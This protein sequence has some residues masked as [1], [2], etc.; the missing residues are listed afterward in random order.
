L[1]NENI[2]RLAFVGIFAVA[3]IPLAATPVLPLIDFYDHLARYFILA[4][5]AVNPVLQRYYEAHWSLLPD[6]GVDLVATP[7]LYFLPPLIAAKAIII[8]IVAVLFSGVIYFNHALTQTRSV[9]VAILIVPLLYS[10]ILNWGFANFLLGLGLVFWAAG[11]WLKTRDRPL[12]AVPVSCVLAPI[13][14]FCHGV[15]FLLYGI[16]LF[17]LELGIF[18]AARD[19]KPAN[20]VYS[21]GLIAIQAIIPVTYF[22]IWKSGYSDGGAVTAVQLSP[23]PFFN[24]L[25]HAVFY[26]L[27]TIARVEEGPALWFDMFTLLIQASV[28]GLLLWKGSISFS[29]SVRPL[30]I[31]ALILTALPLPTLFG[32][33]YIADR[34]PLFSALAVLGVVSV[35]NQKWDRATYVC[36]AILASVVFARI[37]VIAFSWHAYTQTYDE[38][39]TI[40]DRIPPG[41]L[42]TTVML[43]AGHHETD[44]PRCEMYGPLLVT[45]FGGVTPLFADEKQQPLRMIGRLTSH[46]SPDQFDWDNDAQMAYAISYDQDYVLVC[47]LQLLTGSLPKSEDVVERTKHF[48][49]LHMTRQAS[50]KKEALH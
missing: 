23:M 37:M 6:I 8:G 36:G 20:L 22:F 31:I 24:R 1:Y 35:R 30:L 33:G 2:T 14:F 28:V 41:S 7:V 50:M 42:T 13:I 34:I 46:E 10:Y 3:L 32:V 47:N 11:V 12:I 16:L 27:K 4:H 9:L 39:R 25:T 21:L 19:R 17:C 26:H 29:K 18:I 40:A 45:Q 38:F 43:G 49:L 15:A 44:V 5:I 48:A